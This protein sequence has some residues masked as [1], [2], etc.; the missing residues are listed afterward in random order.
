MMSGVMVSHHAFTLTSLSI[1]GTDGWVPLNINTTQV[2][3]LIDLLQEE[4]M[5]HLQQ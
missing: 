4:I 2:L 5:L 1:M 3:N